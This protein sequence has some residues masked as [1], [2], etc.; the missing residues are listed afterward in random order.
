MLVSRYEVTATARVIIRTDDEGFLSRPRRVVRIRSREQGSPGNRRVVPSL[1]T[2]DHC[3][4][5]ATGRYAT[6][7]KA[8]SYGWPAEPFQAEKFSRRTVNHFTAPL[9]KGSDHRGALACGAENV[10]QRA[11]FGGD[12]RLS[13]ARTGKKP[14][15]R[16]HERATSEFVRSDP[17][18]KLCGVLASFF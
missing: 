8:S 5:V 11:R 9:Q 13:C 4:C 2:G 1:Q 12:S 10:Y 3:S 18:V 17:G 14:V 15:V 16:A 7:G 6:G